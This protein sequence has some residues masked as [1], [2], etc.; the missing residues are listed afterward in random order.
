MIQIRAKK[1]RF[2]ITAWWRICL[3]EG[4]GG[5]GRRGGWGGGQKKQKLRLCTSDILGIKGSAPIFALWLS[6]VHLG[7]AGRGKR[8]DR[9]GA[10]GEELAAVVCLPKTKHSSAG[11]IWS[12]L[13]EFD[14][15]II[16]FHCCEPPFFV[17]FL[18][19]SSLSRPLFFSFFFYFFFFLFVMCMTM[20]QC[21]TP[22]QRL[23]ISHL[24]IGMCHFL[25]FC[26]CV[27]V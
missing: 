17:F 8:R 9:A 25:C 27:C 6:V 3:R 20:N 11:P 24:S 13:F 16:L 15:V 12:G 14:R 22:R 5:G 10:V 26:V 1:K 18:S 4:G 23:T 7:S 21:S 19:S 2:V